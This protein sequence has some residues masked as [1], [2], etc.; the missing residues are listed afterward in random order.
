MSIRF[1]SYALDMYFAPRM[2]AFTSASIP[3]MSEVDAEQA[4]WLSNYILNSMLRAKLQ[5]PKRQ[6]VYN[7]LRR[8]HAAFSEYASARS[9]TLAFVADRDKPLCYLDA[10]GHWEAFLAYS[11]QAYLFLGAGQVRW[12]MQNDGS[13]LQ[14]LNFLHNQAKHADR[15][16]QRGEYVD[17]SPLCVWLT[18]EGLS[19][20]GAELTFPDMAEV[21]T[22]L[23]EWASALQDPLTARQKLAIH[24]A[25]VHEP[26]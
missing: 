15:A 1:S 21:L 19:C 16:I 17:D 14:R 11:W 8:S 7:F 12:F 25:Q 5:T 20:V 6:Q 23:A 26:D 3:D 18:N 4:H 24:G 22:D 9:C 13:V 2:S 10:I